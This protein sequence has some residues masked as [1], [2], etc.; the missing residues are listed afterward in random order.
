MEFM[1]KTMV[2]NLI[3][4]LLLMHSGLVPSVLGDVCC[5]ETADDFH[6]WYRRPLY[7]CLKTAKCRGYCLDTATST[8]DAIGHFLT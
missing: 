2:S 7:L 4:S 8:R 3:L 6:C 1:R 5:Q